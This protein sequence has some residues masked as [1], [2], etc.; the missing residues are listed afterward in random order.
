MSAA[1]RERYSA[2]NRAFNTA[3]LCSI[4]LHGLLLYTFTGFKASMKPQDNPAL[5]PIVARLVQPPAP[6]APAPT[7]EPPQPQQEQRAEPPPPP[8]PT[9]VKPVPAPAKPSPVAKPAPKAAPVEPT[10]SAPPTPSPPVSSTPPAPSAPAAPAAPSAP[11]TAPTAPA[12]PAAQSEVADK[13]SLDQYRMQILSAAR[14]YKRYPRVAM[15][16]N[17]EG[18][19]EVVMVIG[20]NGMIASVSVKTSAGHEVLDQ[21]ALDMFKRAKPLVPIPSA[22]RGKEFT[23]TLR[24]IYSLKE[25]ES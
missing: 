12:A 11:T 14:K 21:Q 1:I 18:T 20:A 15:D 8:P 19:A 13:G 3:V 9:A 23:V 10:S 2:S 16:N 25:P 17:W 5:G 4:V 24:A 6:P 22:L 7:P